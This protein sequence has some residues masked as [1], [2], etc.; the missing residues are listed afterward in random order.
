MVARP[1]IAMGLVALLCLPCNPQLASADFPLNTPITGTLTGQPGGGIVNY[2]LV[3]TGGTL[4]VAM[5]YNGGNP[6]IDSAVGFAVYQDTNLVINEQA[7]NGNYGAVAYSVPT[8]NGLN[9]D[10]QAYNYAPNFNA[11]YHLVLSDPAQGV[12]PQSA[13]PSMSGTERGPLLRDSVVR[14]QL[15]GRASG[16]LHNYFFAGDGQ[17]LTLLLDARPRDPIAD[18]AIGLAVFDQWGNMQQNVS[19]QHALSPSGAIVWT[20]VTL[21]NVGY[22]VQVFN[23]QAQGAITYVLAAL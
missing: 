8:I 20:F 9:Y 23:Y 13:S 15:A 4:S 17:P 22:G 7:A 1:L 10:V 2:P 11:A 5:R 12:P 14:Q 21:A 3:G 16:S 18:A 6:G 19:F